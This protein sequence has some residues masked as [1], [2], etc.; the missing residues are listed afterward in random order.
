MVRYKQ[1]GGTEGWIMKYQ[2]IKILILKIGDR[3]LA[4]QSFYK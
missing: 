2:E 4:F 3:T 1:D